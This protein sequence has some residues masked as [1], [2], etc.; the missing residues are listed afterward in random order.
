MSFCFTK[1]ACYYFCPSEIKESKRA[2][3]RKIEKKRE[4]RDKVKKKKKIGRVGRSLRV[5]YSDPFCLSFTHK[6][7]LDE[8]YAKT[9][10]KSHF[11]KAIK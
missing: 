10:I 11:T 1:H 4:E 9:R 8:V 6:M 3:E 2:G 5:P 7:P